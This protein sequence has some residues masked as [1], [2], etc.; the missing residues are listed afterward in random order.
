MKYFLKYIIVLSMFIKSN[1]VWAIGDCMLRPLHSNPDYLTIPSEKWICNV[2]DLPDVP[3]DISQY[4]KKVIF[5]IAPNG[6]QIKILAQSK[7]SNEQILKSYNI[8]SLYLDKYDKTVYANYKDKVANHI[9]KTESV[10]ILLNGADRITQVPQEAMI[11]QPLYELENPITGSKDYLTDNWE[12]RDASYEEI[13]HF[14][15]DNGIGTRYT[16][17]VLKKSWQKELMHATNNAINKKI[18]PIDDRGQL[19]KEQLNEWEPEGSLS[20]EYLAS[21]VDAYYGLWDNWHGKSSMWGIYAPKTREDIKNKDAL[22]WNVVR[23]YFPKFQGQ[24]E[25]ISPDFKGT[26]SLK[27]NEELPYT[28]KSKYLLNVR[29]TG[30]LDSNLLGNEQDN[31]LIGNS[32]SNI[33]DG[34]LGNDTVQVNNVSRNYKIETLKNKTVLLIEIA[35]VKNI[36]YLKNIEK[37]VFQDKTI[38][39]EK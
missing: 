34:G 9:A 7:I 24:V 5:Y 27:Y 29:L 23:Q 3:R 10:L 38:F 16:D 1:S 14:V 18:W 20:Q 12:R 25:R 26:F 32:N 28:N 2:Q 30:N 8:L 17:G 22:G 4:F 37:I 19:L 36:D 15:H 13:L 35:N 39:I 31:I 33:I 6:S 11:G 21:I